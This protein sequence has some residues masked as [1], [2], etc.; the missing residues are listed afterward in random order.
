MKLRK[1][2]LKPPLPDPHTYS[3]N[4]A[5]IEFHFFVPLFLSI[6]RVKLK[7]IQADSIIKRSRTIDR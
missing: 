6:K 1:I 3:N 7:H 4:R 2:E 5:V